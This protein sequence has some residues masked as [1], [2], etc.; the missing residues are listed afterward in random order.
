MNRCENSIT[1]K[2]VSW[3]STLRIL[4]SGPSDGPIEPIVDFSVQLAEGRYR[5]QIKYSKAA[6]QLIVIAR[7][8]KMDT[9]LFQ[10]L[11]NQP[12]QS[13]SLT[14]VINLDDTYINTDLQGDFQTL[15]VPP[16][17]AAMGKFSFYFSDSMNSGVLFSIVS[18]KDGKIGFRLDSLPLSLRVQ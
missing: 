18:E 17:E 9:T 10:N 1:S 6:G 2:I 15:K 5:V 11:D 14:D 12:I 3:V 8:P 16:W 13:T 7:K 4:G